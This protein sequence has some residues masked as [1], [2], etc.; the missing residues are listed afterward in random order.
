LVL[1][2]VYLRYFQII[3]IQYS[4]MSYYRFDSAFQLQFV[5][6]NGVFTGKNFVII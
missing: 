4:K 1:S 3:N 2:E 5:G 6:E